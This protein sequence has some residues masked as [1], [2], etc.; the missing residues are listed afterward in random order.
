M[1]AVFLAAGVVPGL[2]VAV[3]VLG[4]IDHDLT[5]L[6]EYCE[7]VSR[8]TG[9]PI[10]PNYPVVGRDAFRTGTGVHAGA[11]VAL[12]AFAMAQAQGASGRELIAAIVAGV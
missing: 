11:T 3:P 7:R 1:A 8:S 5:M 6:P 4:W 10:P 2:R 12:P 9:V